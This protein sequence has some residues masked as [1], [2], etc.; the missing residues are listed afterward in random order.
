MLINWL[1]LHIGQAGGS[2]TGYDALLQL[3]DGQTRRVEPGYE[4]PQT[5]PTTNFV[6]NHM[7]QVH[8]LAGGKLCSKSACLT[9]AAPSV[10][11]A[12]C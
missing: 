6:G 12:A 8:T 10:Q 11:M 9:S 5:G 3:P 2:S 7:T 4:R 1:V